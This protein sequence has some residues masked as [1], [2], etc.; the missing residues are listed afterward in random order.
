MQAGLVPKRLALSDIFTACGFT[1]RAVVALV[2][3]GAAGLLTL[4][5]PHEQRAAA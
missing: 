5:W 1:L 4:S 3:T 2:E